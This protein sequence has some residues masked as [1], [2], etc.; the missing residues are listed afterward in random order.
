MKNYR[1]SISI[2]NGN[3]KRYTLA[4]PTVLLPQFGNE[5]AKNHFI[6]QTGL[7]L[8]NYAGRL[9]CY[10]KTFKQLYKI[11][12]TYNYAT[13]YYNNASWHNTLMLNYKIE[14]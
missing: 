7:K 4:I 2:Y 10:P 6:K 13:T 9:R 14:K 8:D 12:V 3:N 5:V 1:K 11:F